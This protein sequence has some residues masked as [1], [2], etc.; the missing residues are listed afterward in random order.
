M[1][2]SK[3]PMYIEHP[4][5]C[6]GKNLNARS[7]VTSNENR[8]GGGGVRLL[9]SCRGSLAATS[10]S[11]LYSTCKLVKFHTLYNDSTRHVRGSRQKFFFL[12]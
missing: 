7:E 12:Q 4:T 6:R 2:L 8:V 5:P 1:F 11:G 3:S 10:N 9:C